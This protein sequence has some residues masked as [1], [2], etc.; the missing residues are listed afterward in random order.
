MVDLPEPDSPVNQN[1][2]GR[3]F[4][5]SART[6]LPTSSNCQWMFSARRSECR[7]MPAPTVA[8]LM[9]SIRMKAP[10]VRFSAKGSKA[11]GVRVEMLQMPTSFISSDL[12]ASWAKSLTLI[13]YFRSVTVALL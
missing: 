1:T 13:R 11:I 3:W 6:R 10:V 8:L 7:I 2:A 9:R 4:F 12:A 5:M